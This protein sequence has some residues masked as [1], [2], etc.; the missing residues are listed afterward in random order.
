EVPGRSPTVIPPA[1]AAPRDA[2][3]I[4]PPNPPVTTMAPSPARRRP[5]SSHWA[6]TSGLAGSGP[7][8]S[9]YTLIPSPPGSAQHGRQ[10]RHRALLVQRLVA[11]AALRRLHARGTALRTRALPDG[12]QRGFQEPAPRAVA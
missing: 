10:D 4:A 9:T 5:I 6:A 2:A 3:S 7:T 1:P 8:T 11:V 12:L